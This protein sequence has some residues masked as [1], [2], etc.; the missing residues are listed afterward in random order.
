MKKGE[1][2]FALLIAFFVFI[3]LYMAFGKVRPYCD[4]CPLSEKLRQQIAISNSIYYCGFHLLVICLFLL[5][6]NRN[7]LFIG[8]MSSIA[9]VFYFVLW[10]PF[11]VVMFTTTL[12]K[13]VELMQS[14]QFDWVYSIIIFLMALTMGLM[15]ANKIDHE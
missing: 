14:R 1:K 12:P 5:T 10:L 4:L 2:I 7:N 8:R 15:I 3:T 11:D 9:G 6:Y 13:Q